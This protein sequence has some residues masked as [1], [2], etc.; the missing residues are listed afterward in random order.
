MNDVFRVAD[1]VAV[2]YLGRMVAVLPIDRTDRHH[3]VEL[4]TFGGPVSPSPDGERDG[5]SH[6]N[7]S[8]PGRDL[9]ALRVGV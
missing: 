2:L 9:A 3:V 6:V 7:G 4:M 8:A 5:A 1:R